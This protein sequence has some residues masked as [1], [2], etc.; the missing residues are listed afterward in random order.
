[1]GREVRPRPLPARSPLC[2]FLISLK[3]KSKLLPGASR[4]GVPALR[5]LPPVSFHGLARLS[6]SRM[7]SVLQ[8]CPCASTSGHLHVLFPLPRTFFPLLSHMLFSL[9]PSSFYL[10]V[11][12][13]AKTSLAT[14]SPHFVLAVRL[15]FP[16]TLTARS[17]DARSLN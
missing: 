2:W 8:A 7:A 13:S 15:H 9:P 17:F 16:L 11:A 4:P 3:T 12:A 6:P 5:L 10:Y 1:M 14:F